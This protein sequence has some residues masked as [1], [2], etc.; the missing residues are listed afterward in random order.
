MRR[1]KL[2]IASLILSTALYANE[3]VVPI[4]NL[5]SGA[6][7]SR[8][9]VV[10]YYTLKYKTWSDGTPV[11]IILL[12]DDSPEH[13]EFVRNVLGLTA[14]Q[15]RRMLDFSINSGAGSNLRRVKN[16]AEMVNAVEQTPYSLGYISKDYLILRG[17]NRNVKVL[18][19]I[20]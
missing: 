10:W 7:I 16:V 6:D 8:Q 19:I 12:P 20:H 17:S 15:Y 4:A 1:V 14:T 13:Q 3:P 11:K 2:L 5:P 18:R 9:E